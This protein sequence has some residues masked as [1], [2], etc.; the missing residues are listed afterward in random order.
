MSPTHWDRPLSPPG[1]GIPFHGAA[2]LPLP[3]EGGAEELSQ[4]CVCACT[5]MDVGVCTYLPSIPPRGIKQPSTAP[6]EYRASVRHAGAGIN[7]ITTV[8]KLSLQR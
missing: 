2:A 5:H 7:E 3:N 8:T 1:A 6:V 4:E